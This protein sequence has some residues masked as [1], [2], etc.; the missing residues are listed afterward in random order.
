MCHPKL[1]SFWQKPMSQFM[2]TCLSICHETDLMSSSVG[3]HMSSFCSCSCSGIIPES[4]LTM[5]WLCSAGR[6]IEILSFE[7]PVLLGLA[8]C[9]R[10]ILGACRGLLRVPL[11]AHIRP[12]ALQRDLGPAGP[13]RIAG[14]SLEL[15]PQFWQLAKQAN[16][17][18]YMEGATFCIWNWCN[19]ICT[20][21]SQ[22]V[23]SWQTWQPTHW[24]SL[25]WSSSPLA[26]EPQATEEQAP[27]PKSDLPA[28][29][30]LHRF[31]LRVLK[32]LCNVWKK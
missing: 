3:G 19:T 4:V 32:S 30:P 20:Y 22:T 1:R 31:I 13:R 9:C 10:V 5:A 2:Y 21:T 24:V 14:V 28:N 15:M 6:S 11:F 17:S 25:K 7:S 23:D 18:N 29:W 26:G 12:Q 27:S 16:I 8:G